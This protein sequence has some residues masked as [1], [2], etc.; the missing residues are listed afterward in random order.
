MKGKHAALGRQAEELAANYLSGIGYRVLHRNWRYGRLEVDIIASK[1]DV[2]HIVEVKCRSG[3]KGGYPEQQVTPK[4]FRNLQGAA[5]EF[6]ER[7]PFWNKLQFDVLSVTRLPG[8][9]GFDYFLLEDV[10]FW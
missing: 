7:H 8:S 10:F 1:A 9:R 3:D 6:M 5:A 2:L 4:K